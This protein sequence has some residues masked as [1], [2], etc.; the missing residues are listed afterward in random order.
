MTYIDEGV[1]TGLWISSLVFGSLWWVHVSWLKK[2]SKLALQ[3]QMNEMIADLIATS[4]WYHEDVGVSLFF[5]RF[6]EVRARFGDGNW[7]KD[8]WER[9]RWRERVTEE[10]L[11]KLTG[12]KNG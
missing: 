7:M 1:F 3:A 9:D 6:A 2:K 10:T 8:L 5:S 11:K 4:A 12:A